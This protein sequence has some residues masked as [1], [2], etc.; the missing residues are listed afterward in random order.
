MIVRVGLSLLAG[1]ILSLFGFD[2][3]LIN[4]FS[5]IFNVNMTGSGYYTL[6]GVLG[7]I[8]RRFFVSDG[9]SN[10][11]IEEIEGIVEKYKRK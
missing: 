8:P 7:M 2:G 3:L 1:L 9:K 10:N 5:E 6:F 4:G 11:S